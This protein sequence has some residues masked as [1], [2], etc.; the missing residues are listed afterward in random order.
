MPKRRAP[1]K[2]VTLV[3]GDPSRSQTT[4][5]YDLDLDQLSSLDRSKPS[6]FML[7]YEFKRARD[8]EGYAETERRVMDRLAQLGL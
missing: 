8:P 2:Y 3:G 1:E 6:T 4:G 7:C 5:V